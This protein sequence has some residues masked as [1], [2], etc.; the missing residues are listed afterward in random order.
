MRSFLP[1]PSAT[2]AY[3][4]HPNWDLSLCAGDPHL[5]SRL[6]FQVR[7]CLPQ[8]DATNQPS[9]NHR[10]LGRIGATQRVTFVNAPVKPADFPRRLIRAE[11]PNLDS[12][13]CLPPG[14]MSGRLFPPCLD[15]LVCLRWPR[16]PS[17]FL[18]RTHSLHSPLRSLLPDPWLQ[19]CLLL[20]STSLLSFELAA[21]SWAPSSPRKSPSSCFPSPSATFNPPSPAPTA[22]TLTCA[23][24][25]TFPLQPKLVHQSRR[26][27][28]QVGYSGDPTASEPLFWAT[29]SHPHCSLLNPSHS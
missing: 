10:I 29:T 17:L 8:P 7:G 28:S 16:C 11:S 27:W 18:I 2:T 20:V 22:A 25:P 9:P 19:Q 26:A 14:C 24:I 1:G 6:W 4:S 15:N 13:G 21:L 5:D 3:P 12:E 23:R